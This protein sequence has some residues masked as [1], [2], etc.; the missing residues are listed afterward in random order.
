MKCPRCKTGFCVIE[1][2]YSEG[3]TIQY[4]RCVNCSHQMFDKASE[5]PISAQPCQRHL[6]PLVRFASR[7][8]LS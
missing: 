1:R 3:T 6:D 7:T 5:P 2:Y 4:L 8:Q